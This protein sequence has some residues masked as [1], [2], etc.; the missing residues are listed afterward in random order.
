MRNNLSYNQF[1]NA[2]QSFKIFSIRD[3]GK[4]FPEFDSRRLVEWQKKEYIQKLTN[5]WYIFSDITPYERL[6]FR[7]SNCL[8]MPSYISLESALSYYHLIPEAVYTFQA[9]TTR[10]TIQYNTPKGYFNY[11]NIKPE[12]FFG[13]QVIHVDNLPV[14]I[15]DA[16]KAVLDL[17]Y[18]NATLHSEKDI[19]E[20]RFN[21]DEFQKMDWNKLD[22][23]QLAFG[24]KVLNNRIKEL[25]KIVLHVNA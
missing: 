1:K 24:S 17:L 18:L 14:L 5:K 8:C 20:L 7:I 10:K 2:L 13:Y 23:Y 12:L 4:A 19:R 25:K 3:V 21:R 22:Y 11:R 9:I 16:E 6:S 15:A